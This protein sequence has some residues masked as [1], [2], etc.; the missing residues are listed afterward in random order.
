MTRSA[1]D[2]QGDQLSDEGYE[3]PQPEDIALEQATPELAEHL[4]ALSEP[5]AGPPSGP[6]EPDEDG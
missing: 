5:E 2:E 6:A 1:S 4:A 3:A